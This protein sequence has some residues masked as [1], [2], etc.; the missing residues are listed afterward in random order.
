MEIRYWLAKKPT[1]YQL[2]DL[3]SWKGEFLVLEME[4]YMVL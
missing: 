1:V 4:C 3:S 2:A